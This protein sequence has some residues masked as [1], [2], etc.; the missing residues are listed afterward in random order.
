[1]HNDKTIHAVWLT[2][3][4][5][6]EGSLSR[7]SGSN[8]AKWQSS[9]GRTV[10]DRNVLVVMT[11]DH[12]DWCTGAYGNQEVDTPNIDYLA[13]D[14]VRMEN[15]FCP[16]PV[17]SPS[18]ASFFTGLRASQHG[19]HDWINAELHPDSDWLT[20]AVTLPELLS[21]AGY[22]T[23]LVG[24]W[25][26]GSDGAERVFDHAITLHA[27]DA[28]GS[29]FTVQRDRR[30]TD[31]AIEF[32][33]TRGGEAS[34]FFL[35]VGLAATHLPWRDQPD[36]LVRRYRGSDFDDVPDDPTY[37]F[38]GTNV[39]RPDDPDEARAQYYASAEGV[40]EQVGRLLDELD[41][42]G[43]TEETLTVYT[44]DHGHNCGH[45]GLWGKGN[46]T[47]PQNVLE[48]SIRVPLVFGTHE[49]LVGPQVRDEFV[50][51]TD[52]F[53]TLLDFAGVEPPDGA[54]YPGESYRP[55]LTGAAGGGAWEQVQI[56]EYAD[57]RMVRDER[58]KLVRRLPD[59]PDL[60]FDLDADPR[61]TRNVVDEP[62]YADVVERLNARLTEAFDTDAT[63]DETGIPVDA[64]PEYNGE[65]AWDR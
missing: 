18:R 42:Q 47:S 60:L 46:G 12:G 45:H 13:A 34:P 32:L 52:T 6:Y 61:E 50:D 44:A 21:E 27:D 20:D 33:R 40:D 41:A 5:Y 16:T 26:C 17:C 56:C 58:H 64:L 14:G 65:E 53:R 9:M 30:T 39:L 37:R 35:F 2:R 3:W 62:R 7:T 8:L 10:S 51:H 4:S 36:R 23:G 48:E 28:D 29:F 54:D 1:M 43:L 15:S 49:E 22:T 11:D 59:G 24:K 55:Q 31:N 63:E 25:H 19:V 57:V 38:G